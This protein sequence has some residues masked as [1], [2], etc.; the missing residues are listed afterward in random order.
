M[1]KGSIIFIC[2]VMLFLCGC[3]FSSPT[4][5]F[6]ASS[7]FPDGSDLIKISYNGGEVVHEGKRWF[8]VMDVDIGDR[9]YIDAT[10]SEGPVSVSI[11]V[12][13]TVDGEGYSHGSCYDSAVFS[14]ECGFTVAA[15][16]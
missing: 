15:Q 1:K 8:A 5:T 6:T 2:G 10:V 7:D 12:G 11:S 3:D 16:Y 14:A 4:A 9:V 13:S